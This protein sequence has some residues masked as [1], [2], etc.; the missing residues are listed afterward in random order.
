MTEPPTVRAGGGGG[1]GEW[2]ILYEVNDQP[3]S[4]V[5]VSLNLKVYF[6][7][8]FFYHNLI[9]NFS[10]TFGIQAVQSQ[11]FLVHF[12]RDPLLR[13][14]FLPYRL[15]LLQDFGYSFLVLITIVVLRCHLNSNLFSQRGTTF[16]CTLTFSSPRITT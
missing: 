12:L 8:I 7:T 9:S 16:I 10:N 6:P 14:Y 13:S 4:N 5:R 11:R 1:R 3:S 15:I 2:A